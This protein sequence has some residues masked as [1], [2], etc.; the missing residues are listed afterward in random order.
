M[1]GPILPGETLATV[2]AIPTASHPMNRKASPELERRVDQLDGCQGRW[3]LDTRD[4]SNR[5]YDLHDLPAM[6]CSTPAAALA[7][8]VAQ[9][10]QNCRLLFSP[11]YLDGDSGYGYTAP[12]YYVSNERTFRDCYAKELE[13]ADGDGPG[14]ALDIRYL[15]AEMIEAVVSLESYPILDEDNHSDLERDLQQEEWESWAQSD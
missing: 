10:W 8:C 7:E 9:R 5:G 15:T 2:R 4:D 3:I 14:L 12:S 6:G 1:N 13:N 11:K